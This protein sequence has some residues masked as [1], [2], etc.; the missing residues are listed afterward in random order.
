VRAGER[1]RHRGG[2]LAR[3]DDIQGT[4]DGQGMPGEGADEQIVGITGAQR[5]RDDRA[6]VAPEP[7]E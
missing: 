6:C 3:R 2:G 1:V 5:A 4:I 7:G